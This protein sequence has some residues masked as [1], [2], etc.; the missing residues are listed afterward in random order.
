M[1]YVL[2]TAHA[3]TGAGTFVAAAPIGMLAVMTSGFSSLRTRT[4]SPVSYW[5]AGRWQPGN[6]DGWYPSRKLE[7]LQT[8]WYPFADSVT[9][10]G[11]TLPSG[12]HVTFTEL[13]A[14]P[15]PNNTLQPWDRNAAPLN[16][17]FNLIASAGSNGNGF[18]YT[19]PV[20]R[21]LL[22]ASG[23]ISLRRTQVSSAAG[24]TYIYIQRAGGVILQLQEDTNVVG[25]YVRADLS[26]SSLV[27]AA[28][29][30]V[31]VDYNVSITGGQYQLFCM[32]ACSLFDA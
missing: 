7:H 21:K 25:S 4:D 30:V 31:R 22:I 24:T 13:V 6:A 20:G 12:L 27:L 5:G 19:V 3:V 23:W 11:Y 2:G 17:S 16:L 8:L 29:E 9:R 15:V 26:P 14:A 10:F 28:G 18:T 32:L 1:P